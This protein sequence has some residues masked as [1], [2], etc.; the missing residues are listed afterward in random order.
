SQS[1]RITMAMAMN[2]RN[3]RYRMN[4][5]DRSVVPPRTRL[6]NP[7]RITKTKPTI[8]ATRRSLSRLGDMVTSFL[9][10]QTE[11][12]LAGK[13]AVEECCRQHAF[14]AYSNSGRQRYHIMRPRARMVEGMLQ[15]AIHDL[16]SSFEC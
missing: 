11:S 3:T 15:H 6:I 4:S 12:V 10:G 9:L 2:E 14:E 7:R 5:F 13:Y 8:T 16:G 1:T